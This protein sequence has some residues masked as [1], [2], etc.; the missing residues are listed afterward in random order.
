MSLLITRES[1]HQTGPLVKLHDGTAVG[2]IGIAVTVVNSGGNKYAMDGSTQG[3]ITIEQGRTYYF[4]VSDSSVATHPLQFST[5]SDGTHGG[6]SAY[7]TGVTTSL[8]AGS[9]GAYVLL[10]TSSSTPSTLYYYCS[11]HPGMGGSVF[12]NTF[13]S[14]S[15]DAAVVSTSGKVGIGTVAAG[16][17]ISHKL[18]VN[19]DIRVRGNNIRDNSGGAALTF[20]GSGNTQVDGNLTVAAGNTVSLNGVTY[21]FPSSDGSSGQFLSTN[22]G[23]TLSF[24]TASGGG[25]SSESSASIDL[26]YSNSAF[27]LGTNTYNLK[28]T[29]LTG[30]TIPANATVTAILLAT[31]EAFTQNSGSPYG[32]VLA[33]KLGNVYFK[34][35]YSNLSGSYVSTSSNYVTNSSTGIEGSVGVRYSVGSSSINPSIV[36]NGTTNDTSNSSGYLTD[37]TIRLKVYYTT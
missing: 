10:E 21:T 23:G 14:H 36:I 34:V 3:T 25:G 37:G 11:S 18:D 24:A 1:L 13:A 8:A 20:D 7:T 31:T 9:A 4:D 15:V 29:A 32:E 16:Y 2:T 19:G 5:T 12:K 17:T 26:E 27:D 35:P 28:T 30:L 22:G 6:G 33:I